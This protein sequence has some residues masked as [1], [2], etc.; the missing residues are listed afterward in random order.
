MNERN[1][2]DFG[3]LKGPVKPKPVEPEGQGAVVEQWPS[4]SPASAPVAPVERQSKP[5]VS[6]EAQVSIRGPHEIIERFKGSCQVG[7][8]RL[9][10]YDKIAG[11]LDLEDKLLELEIG[12]RN[13]EPMDILLE[14]IQR[15]R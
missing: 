11:L 10:Y 6:L 15:S 5:K 8:A 3:A 13:A 12:G 14:L 7:R 2:L 9:S 1:D 4:R